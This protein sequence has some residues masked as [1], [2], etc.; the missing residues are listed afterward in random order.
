MW[1]FQDTLRAIQIHT[2][3]LYRIPQREESESSLYAL[4][5]IPLHTYCAHFIH[6]CVLDKISRPTYVRG[7]GQRVPSV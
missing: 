2:L 3:L 7:S 5:Y 1:R 4:R 6:T